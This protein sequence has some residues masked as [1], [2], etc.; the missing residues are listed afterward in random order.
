MSAS[1]EALRALELKLERSGGKGSA[2]RNIKR[3]IRR[4]RKELGLFEGG[5]GDGSGAGRVGDGGGGGASG[6]KKRKKVKG[7]GGG[8]FEGGSSVTKAVPSKKRKREGV[9]ST[10]T[11]TSTST[12]SSSLS[13]SSSSSSSSLPAARSNG[14]NG[15]S[16]SSDGDAATAV[17][18][19][20]QPGGAKRARVALSA[21]QQR[22]QKKLEGGSFRWL[23]EKL[24]TSTGAEALRMYREDPSLYD[25]YHRGYR[26]QVERWP[27]N[28][29]D[30][31]IAEVRRHAPEPEEEGGG[32]GD[33]KEGKKT[34]DKK[35]KKTTKKKKR[36]PGTWKHIADFGCG[37]ARL[38]RSVKKTQRVH[39]F[40]LVA[41]NDSVTACDMA[42]V[43]LR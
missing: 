10:S 38:S 29:L 39:S 43:P 42:R 6:G 40:D 36:A 7:G 33:G 21:L 32:E 17:E 19:P 34:N 26:S 11:S 18:L 31:I 1:M 5:D 15:S 2:R 8:M 24:Y 9:S 3:K 25:V 4:M 16:S 41:H 28:P 23:N 22:F 27:V 13:S 20:K 12:S 30:T 14:K 35:K 37:D